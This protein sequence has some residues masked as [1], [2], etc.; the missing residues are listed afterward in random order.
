MSILNIMNV[1]SRL[2]KAA[3]L[4]A[5]VT[6]VTAGCATL[7]TS[8]P[9][10]ED[11]SQKRRER[12]R[13]AIRSFAENR[14]LAEFQAAQAR[15][16]QGD[17]EG[18]REDLQRLLERTPDHLE[19]RLLLAESLLSDN[20][21]GEAV[22]CLEPAMPRHSDDARVYYTMGL[23]LEAL[24]RRDGAVAYYERAVELEPD[25]E[26]Y[27]VSYQPDLMSGALPDGLPESPMEPTGP[28]SEPRARSAEVSSTAREVPE[29]LPAGL[30]SGPIGSAGPIRSA[31]PFDPEHPAALNAEDS[32]RPATSGRRVFHV[33]TVDSDAAADSAEA[34]DPAG[35]T[36]PASASASMLVRKGAAAMAAGSVEVARAYFREAIGFEPHNPKLPISAAVASLRHNQPDVAVELLEQAATVFPDSAAIHRILGTALYRRGDYKS[37]QVA[38]QHALSLDKSSALA[39]LLMGCT[40]VKLGQSESAESYFRQ[41]RT[42]DPRYTIGR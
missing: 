5:L 18:C 19:A 39:Y 38:L 9:Q 2:L 20:R 24:G 31:A 1:S 33:Q 42:I 40:L 12:N 10:A 37:S 34:N 16:E 15:W 30:P 6:T 13:A 14:D 28:L 22:R 26:V 7:K 41:A 11:I 8:L 4:I 17:I 35:D 27:A 23:A 36:A 21:P 29:E 32:A 3:W 25:N